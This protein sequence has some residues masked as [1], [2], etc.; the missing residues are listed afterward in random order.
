MFPAHSD[1]QNSRQEAF[2]MSSK[3]LNSIMGPE[4][5][6]TKND[7]NIE[8]SVAFQTVAPAVVLRQGNQITVEKMCETSL[9]TMR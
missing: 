2:L 9:P 6:N 7:L 1:G 4:T 8:P 3:E 5:S